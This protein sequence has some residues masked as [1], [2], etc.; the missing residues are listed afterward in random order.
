[1]RARFATFGPQGQRLL[2]QIIDAVKG[3]LM[4]SL[5]SVFLISLGILLIGLVVVVFWPEIQLQPA[6]QETC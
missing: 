2:E 4:Q 6:Q 3:G 1:M 5:H